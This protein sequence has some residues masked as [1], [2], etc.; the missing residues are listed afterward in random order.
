MTGNDSDERRRIG[1]VNR[2]KMLMALGAGTAVGLAGRGAA[3]AQED[4]DGDGGVDVEPCPPCIV[5]YSGYLSPSDVD[6]GASQ[7]FAPV[8]PWNCV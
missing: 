4:E 6:T 8:R 1:S 2:R 3:I 7:E 5:P